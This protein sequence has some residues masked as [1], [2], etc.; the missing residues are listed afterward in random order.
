MNKPLTFHR[1]LSVV[2]I[3]FVVL[4]VAVLGFSLVGNP[5]LP[6][7]ALWSQASSLQHSLLFQARLPRV[8]LAVFVGAALSS[9]GVAFQ[10]LLRN[11]LADPYILGVSGGAALGGVLA[12][13]LGA[14]FELIS[15]TAFAFA[16]GSLIL[17]YFIAQV[18]GRLPVHTL[19]L[20]GVIFNAFAF[21]LILLINS[22]VN[23]GQAHQILFLLLG[24]LDAQPMSHVL[25]VGGF[26]LFGFLILFFNAQKMNV[27]S[28]GEE[29]SLQLG[30]SVE[31]YRKVLFFA[32]SLM[33]G[34][35]VAIAGLIG[36]VGLV[37][38]HLVRLLFGSDHRLLLPAS[39]LGGGLFLVICDFAARTFFSGSD[40]QTQ[41]PIG[42]ITALVG[43]PF[44]VLLL[45]KKS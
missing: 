19:L 35:T 33:V 39:A 23:I 7:D 37:V 36:F 31:R 4:V 2:L 25:W 32:A 18:N 27:V 43:G 6:L 45:K 12:L 11:P 41:L 26:T 1:W 44:F 17:I 13:A 10:S 21:A 40:F 24:S 42:V 38:P 16:L 8:L 9:S 34:A 20:T 22:L 30:V 28:L 3:L 15:F 5:I 29:T 14:S